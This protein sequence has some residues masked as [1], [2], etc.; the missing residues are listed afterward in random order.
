M[1]NMAK[2]AYLF[3]VMGLNKEALGSVNPPMK[4]GDERESTYS[5]WWTAT[6]DQGEYFNPLFENMSLDL[7]DLE[8]ATGDLVALKSFFAEGADYQVFGTNWEEDNTFEHEGHGTPSSLDDY[9]IWRYCM[10]NTTPW[11]AD[12][13]V[14]GNT[15]GV[16]YRGKL[17]DS[18]RAIEAVIPSEYAATDGEKKGEPIYA[19][20]NVILGTAEQLFKFAMNQKAADDNTG[21]Y[22]AVSPAYWDIVKKEYN[23]NW[24]ETKNDNKGGY[25]NTGDNDWWIEIE[26]TQNPLE[27]GQSAPGGVRKTVY[28]HGELNTVDIQK[29]LVAAGFTI[30]RPENVNDKPVYYCY[31]IYWNRHND[32]KQNTI[33]GDME[34]A[35]VR[36][37]VYKLSISK[38]LNLGHPGEP[39]DDP[40]PPTPGTPDEKDEFWLEVKCLVLPWE[41][42]INNVEF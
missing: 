38:V 19:Y 14:N 28:H 23:K 31:Y 4:F 1:I 9:K 21:V 33:M 35:T 5:Q 29:A 25:T 20:G 22:E 11:S 13:Q 7:T 41:V 34:F 2:S 12:N 6:P 27:P 32:N 17:V 10:E 24:D 42:R 30:Y 3:K 26:D 39:G 40:Y 8:K 15:T 37:N 36:N 18:R 16:V